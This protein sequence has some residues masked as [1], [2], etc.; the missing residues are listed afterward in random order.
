MHQST[1]VYMLYILYKKKKKW[2]V[3][4]TQ[5]LLIPVATLRLCRN[6]TRWLHTTACEQDAG[7]CGSSV[8]FLIILFI[9]YYYLDLSKG[10]MK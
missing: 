8:A 5:Q 6:R 4:K 1:N 9:K 7:Q 2:V 10:Q 3:E